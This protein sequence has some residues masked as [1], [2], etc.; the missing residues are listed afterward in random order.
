MTTDTSGSAAP[1]EEFPMLSVPVQGHP[2]AYWDS[3]MAT[4]IHRDAIAAWVE[5]CERIGVPADVSVH[6]PGAQASDVVKTARQTVARFIGGRE[7]EVVFTKNATEALRI[8]SFGLQLPK[9]AQV[10]VAEGEHYA[11]LLNWVG[12]RQP[13]PVLVRHRPEDGEV[14]LDHLRTVMQ[15]P[16]VALVCLSLVNHVTGTLLPVAEVVS[17]ARERGALVMLDACQGIGRMPIDVTQLGCDFLVFSSVHTYAPPGVGVLWGRREALDRLT[18]RLGSGAVRRVDAG[19]RFVIP[20]DLPQRCESGTKNAPTIAALGR[21]LARL[22]R[23]G[24][25]AV[26]AHDRWIA[27]EL[28]ALIADLPGAR[29][30]GPAD[31]ARRVGL[32]SFTVEEPHRLMTCER[33]AAT[34]SD[35]D[36]VVCSG[37]TLDGAPLLGRMQCADAIRLS[38]GIH[39]D[40]E[41]LQRAARA[42]GTMLPRL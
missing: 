42:L 4:P 12:Q 17:L 18:F 13:V 1:R 28:V 14:D 3:A 23:I 5:F 6:E 21:A 24:M 25:S 11:N 39:T 32:A 34:L 22:S 16:K 37:G 41:D 27:S 8:I 15:Q 29:L 10:V 33:F 31:P 26:A 19:G 7:A 38:G 2:M 20:A 36:G 30:L 40:R 9:D 35:S